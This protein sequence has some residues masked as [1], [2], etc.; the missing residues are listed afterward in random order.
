MPRRLRIGHV[1]AYRVAGDTGTYSIS[2]QDAAVL[3]SALV[4]AEAGSY[5][6]TGQDAAF[7]VAPGSTPDFGVWQQLTWGAVSRRQVTNPGAGSG[8]WSTTVAV[9]AE[10]LTPISS[11]TV[12][13]RGFCRAT[14]G[15]PGFIYYHGSLHSDY[16]GNE[17]DKFDLTNLSSTTVGLSINHQP[18][19]PPQGPQSGYGSGS[20]SYLH[21]QYSPGL[22][23]NTDWQPYT[24]HNWC[25][26]T[27]HPAYGYLLNSAYAL[28]NGSTTGANPNG[29]GSGYVVSSKLF[30]AD[31]NSLSKGLVRYNETTGKY[32]LVST[33]PAHPNQ[34]AGHS[35]F[36]NYTQSLLQ[37]NCDQFNLTVWRHRS[38]SWDATVWDSKSIPTFSTGITSNFWSSGNNGN[39]LLA[40][41]MDRGRFLLY[42]QNGPVWGTVSTT[43]DRVNFENQVYLYDSYNKTIARVTLGSNIVSALLAYPSGDGAVSF[44]VDRASRTVYCVAVAATQSGF[45]VGTPLV[46]K[47]PFDDLATWTETTGSNLP[48][49]RV[50]F[51]IDREPAKIYNGHLFLLSWNGTGA[52]SGVRIDRVRLGDWEVPASFTFHRHDY[53]TQSYTFPSPHGGSIMT[54]KHCNLAYREVDAQYYEMAGDVG[55]SFVQSM[56]RLSVSPTAY[57]FATELDELTIAP[58]G[59][60][61]VASPDD[62]AWAYCGQSNSNAALADKFIYMRGGDGISIRSNVYMQSAYASDAAAL[63]DR[64]TMAKAT[65]YDPANNRF[66]DAGMESWPVEDGSMSF[67]HPGLWPAS[68][69]RAGAFDRSTNTMFRFGS[70]G[71]GNQLVAYDFDAQTIRIWT[72]GLTTIDG[73]TVYCDHNRRIN[74]THVIHSSKKWFTDT[75]V[76]PSRNRTFTNFGAEHQ[77][78]WI[79]ETDGKMYVVSPQTGLLWC[80]E[81]RGTETSDSDGLHIPFY[82]VGNRIPLDDT[83]F[84]ATVAQ[85]WTGPAAQGGWDVTMNSFLVPFKG[86]LFWTCN[87][88]NGSWGDARYA[89]WRRLG[90]EGEW[91]PIT[92]PNDWM[93]NSFGA[94]SNSINNDEILAIQNFHPDGVQACNAFYIIR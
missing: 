79:N 26:N 50:N 55:D 20:G 25:F 7:A 69:A 29:E 32:S 57:T 6:V 76:S 86:G 56:Y 24:F 5:A 3:R 16:P 36:S 10:A 15:Q 8:A 73:T 54:A 23:D 59:F 52:D 87:S 78:C 17:I 72:W 53:T 85:G 9:A 38:G 42:T 75:S 94:K 84:N 27:Y 39:G 22:S 88:P 93:C 90:Y 89:F 41:H 61:R 83:H 30:Y 64:W 71:S 49:V 44:A 62:G 74:H 66:T 45:R 21:R 67:D 28:A 91:T 35:D 81:T 34:V 37:L 12:P 77:A 65:I 63:A 58:V 60:V 18:V 4:T 13:A 43:L 31:T 19:I 1:R 33:H 11:T 70:R 68:A 47:S 48:T 82:P 80:F 2:G 14:M 46:W 51:A 40:L 92:L